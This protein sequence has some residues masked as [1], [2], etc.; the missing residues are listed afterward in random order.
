[1]AAIG[2]VYFEGVA[3]F[4]GVGSN[5]KSTFLNTIRLILGSY[6]GQLNPEVFMLQK[7]GQQPAG[8][9][10]VKGKRF[11]TA[12]E[13]EEGRRLSSSILK[14]LSSTDPIT[15][16]R[17]Y[18]NPI[19]FQ[20]THTLIL[21]TNFLPKISS[22]DTG[23]WRRIAVVPFKAA[24]PENKRIQNYALEIINYDA[25]AIL[26]W[27]IAG[28]IQFIKNGYNLLLPQCVIEATKHYRQEEDWLG[29]FMAECCKLGTDFEIRGGELYDAYSAWTEKN[30]EYCRRSRDFASALEAAGFEKRHTVIGNMWYG[31]QLNKD[32]N[33]QEDNGY[34][35]QNPFWDQ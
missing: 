4:F 21:A 10:E 34:Y 26:S 19:T 16:R 30:N 32:N 35:S 13:T 9:A 11:I 14:Q 22:T 1:M 20:P 6:A 29:N 23:T 25:D 17:L 33:S 24:I 8:I 31:L 3:I 12:V 27:I 28:A 15:A 7:N 2:E 18:E 5:G